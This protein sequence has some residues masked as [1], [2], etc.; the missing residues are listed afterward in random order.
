VVPHRP[1]PLRQPA[2][3]VAD[4]SGLAA[5]EG[6]EEG[7]D[8][9]LVRL[10]RDDLLADRARVRLGGAVAPDVDASADAGASELEPAGDLAD[11][12]VVAAE[13]AAAGARGRVDLD[14][15]GER[16][17]RVVQRLEVLLDDLGT[18]AGG[19]DVTGDGPEL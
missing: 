1:R 7:L 9:R 3:P 18:D 11:G 16:L 19:D 17:E 2:D 15:G 14:V 6:A 8:R 13:D 10:G 5:A 12:L 4:G